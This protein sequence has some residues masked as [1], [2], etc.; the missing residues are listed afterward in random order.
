ME[1]V[2]VVLRGKQIAIGLLISTVL[3]LAACSAEFQRRLAPDP[4]LINGPGQEPGLAS[5]PASPEAT[6][7][8]NAPESPGAIA[9]PASP[10]ESPAASPSPRP[11]ANWRPGQPSATTSSPGAPR[12]APQRFTDLAQAPADLQPYITDLAEL[13]VLQITPAASEFKPGQP[14]TRREFARWLMA[15]N[16]EIFA[17]QPANKIRPAS[18]SETPAF[19][20][21][22]SS[23]PDFAAIQGLASAG[24]VPSPL[25]GN[26]TI[27]TFRPDA[28]LT[29]EDL[30]L[31]KT[32]LDL[33][34][35]LPNATLEAVQQTWGFQDAASI[36]PRAQ[37]AVLADFQN[38]DLSNIRR[39]FGYTTLFQ[40]K[41]PVTRAEAAAVLWF[42]GTQGNGLSAREAGQ[43]ATEPTSSQT[44]EQV[45]GQ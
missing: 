40:P 4:A 45:G 24:L 11:P 37:R 8:P 33:R 6:P 31:W 5:P 28:P 21:V 22:P 44:A 38:A 26:S 30:I 42:F 43:Q 15:A 20:D 3:P 7:S 13:G 16:N 23:D 35:S 29:R 39:A 34:R 27:V 17:N 41:K 19:Q 32:P 9:P 18:P 1:L 12:T 25:S 36:D 2:T 10:S 14:I